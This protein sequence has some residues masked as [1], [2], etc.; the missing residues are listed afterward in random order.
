LS[1]FKEMI[2]ALAALR[3]G[4]RNS[5]VDRAVALSKGATDVKP[6]V[7][8]YA[9]LISAGMLDR[10]FY[11][12]EALD[13]LPQ[14]LRAWRR[15]KHTKRYA[16]EL[17]ELVH[18]SLKLLDSD[19]KQLDQ[20]EEEEE[21]AD[22]IQKEKTSSSINKSLLEEAKSRR[23]FDVAAYM[24]RL[25]CPPAMDMY[26]TLLESYAENDDAVNHY[27]YAFLYRLVRVPLSGH[28]SSGDLVRQPIVPSSTKITT[29]EPL[30]YQVRFLRA[31]AGLIA[32]KQRRKFPSLR[33]LISL[34]TDTL[35]HFDAHAKSNPLLYVEALFSHAGPTSTRWVE[36]LS[37]QYADLSGPLFS[38]DKKLDEINNDNESNNEEEKEEILCGGESDE[39]LDFDTAMKW[40]T[41]ALKRAKKRKKEKS[42]KARW[43]AAEDAALS[44]LL[45]DAYEDDQDRD[46]IDYVR[47]SKLA[48]L[49]PHHQE[50]KALKRRL[51]ILEKAA[52]DLE[53]ATGHISDKLRSLAEVKKKNAKKNYRSSSSAK[54]RRKGTM[55]DLFI[56]DDDEDE[57]VKSKDS[58]DEDQEDDDDEDENPQQ[59][60][61]ERPILSNNDEDD[62]D[63]EDDRWKQPSFFKKRAALAAVEEATS[64]EKPSQRRR[65]QR[66][67]SD[68]ESDSDNS[69]DD[70]PV[71]QDASAH[72]RQFIQE[73]EDSD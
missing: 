25:A 57:E 65:L 19:K 26:A 42:K 45:A 9:A 32:D 60:P 20:E 28:Y 43:T 27:V 40:D 37:N 29:M 49:L 52:S 6:T 56:A 5:R 64:Q 1:V 53:G 59:Q 54:K 30:L 36:R 2:R 58:D 41:D 68:T 73:D 61:V 10:I 67:T 38:S 69:F 4:D 7:P 48:V 71:S 47:L 23:Q 33:P 18:V 66:A 51:G 22:D 39:E 11:N 70:M 12:A 62:D 3:D 8:G 50:R 34:A 15:G 13:P 17:A 72:R 14:L 55:D 21:E 24:L 46:S 44:L 31:F 35:R 63:D 16:T